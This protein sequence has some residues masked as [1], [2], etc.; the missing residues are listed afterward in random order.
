MPQQHSVTI[1]SSDTHN[2]N[3]HY[4]LFRSN[5]KYT[6][7]D[8]MTG[9]LF[10]LLMF[11]LEEALQFMLAE[12]IL[13]LLF[14][15]PMSSPPD[16]LLSPVLAV[17]VTDTLD[18][19]A[20]CCISAT[21]SSFFGVLITF[22]QIAPNDLRDFMLDAFYHPPV[23]ADTPEYEWEGN[24]VLYLCFHYTFMVFVLLFIFLS[25]AAGI[26]IRP[27][28]PS[29]RPSY[30][31]YTWLARIC[32]TPRARLAHVLG[33][34]LPIPSQVLDCS[35]KT[36]Q[37]LFVVAFFAWMI[38]AVLLAAWTTTIL[39]TTFA[40]SSMLWSG[41]LSGLRW[42]VLTPTPCLGG[43]STDDQVFCWGQSPVLYLRS[44]T[45]GLADWY[46]N[47]YEDDSV[48]HFPII[49][50][51]ITTGLTAFACKLLWQD[52]YKGLFTP[53][54]VREETRLKDAVLLDYQTFL[55][56]LISKTDGQKEVLVDMSGLLASALAQSKEL[57]NRLLSL[58]TENSELENK[59]DRLPWYA[60]NLSK[61]M[62]EALS[63][64]RQTTALQ[65]QLDA[66]RRDTDGNMALSKIQ[67]LNTQLATLHQEVE[68]LR[69]AELE[70]EQELRS[71]HQAVS[72]AMSKATEAEKR[73][74]H[75]SQERSNQ[76]TDAESL[77]Q[78]Y[79]KLFSTCE[80]LSIDKHNLAQQLHEASNKAQ[81]AETS[82]S[83]FDLPGKHPSSHDSCVHELGETTKRLDVTTATLKLQSEEL[84]ATETEL[85]DKTTALAQLT[86]TLRQTE[87][88][89][90]E[91]E[92]SAAT[93]VVRD[94]HKQNEVRQLRD[95]LDKEKAESRVLRENTSQLE[96][97]LRQL[98]SQAMGD[99]PSASLSRSRSDNDPLVESLRAQLRD[100]EAE[101]QRATIQRSNAQMANRGARSSPFMPLRRR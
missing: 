88:R 15:V 21:A 2:Y 40:F 57:Y 39:A 50:F 70:K 71:L 12:F 49:T 56:G 85:D 59:C 66:L 29:W 87:Q 64:R 86:N 63:L 33:V 47:M 62:N 74:D 97:E 25:L 36:N 93:Q 1:K 68:V 34:C 84:G 41:V 31:S 8:D 52:K 6:E 72:T 76:A 20:F 94:Q 18:V 99:S 78:E 13:Y 75:L 55:A 60:C 98:R 14:E 101:L 69:K 32:A 80:Q 7:R 26:M 58:Q 42:T 44:I 54:F 38:V 23:A 3:S 30:P 73:A 77:R 45:A 91:L 35:A 24:K 46:D 89:L 95:K 82:A 90:A 65:D 96:S 83:T 100:K 79:S 17:P 43:S 61:Y 16:I 48:R 19:L 28:V 5:T 37:A 27:E 92:P 81:L 53:E 11:Y 10:E 67:M 51:P 9:S 22:P 4:T